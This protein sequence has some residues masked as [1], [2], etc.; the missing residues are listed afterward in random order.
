MCKPFGRAC[1]GANTCAF[2]QRRHISQPTGNFVDAKCFLVA[3]LPTIFMSSP[4]PV[5]IRA[6]G[7]TLSR[8][9]ERQKSLPVTMLYFIRTNYC[10]SSR[11]W[12]P[13]V[14]SASKGNSVV[15]ILCVFDALQLCCT[16][17]L[18]SLSSVRRLLSVT[19][20]LWLAV[21]A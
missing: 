5:D 9:A 4:A 8:P 10:S 14:R 20:V 2:Q 21:R 3:N 19:D 6:A 15:L 1:S 17:P 7:E 18:A 16:A 12:Q 11:I 13:S